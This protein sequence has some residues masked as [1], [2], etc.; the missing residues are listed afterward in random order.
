[1]VKF[2]INSLVTGIEDVG[3]IQHSISAI[4]I[5]STV[6]KARSVETN[7]AVTGDEYA[8]LQDLALPATFGSFKA[9]S[10]GLPEGLRGAYVKITGG[11]DEASGQIRLVL[12]SYRAQIVSPAGSFSFSYDKNG[13]GTIDAGETTT[14]ALSGDVSAAAGMSL[15][16][17][18]VPTTTTSTSWACWSSHTTRRLWATVA[19]QSCSTPAP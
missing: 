10:A 3:D 12:G 15:S 9:P 19:R 2:G 6:T 16:P 4:A 18:V 8:T 7:P 1:M 11:D 17:G 5:E 14:V 13:N